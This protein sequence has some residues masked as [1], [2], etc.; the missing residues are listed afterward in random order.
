[1]RRGAGGPLARRPS[2]RSRRGTP[3][4][5]ATFMDRQLQW[6]H[7]TP[8][9]AMAS[10]TQHLTAPGCPRHIDHANTT[11]SLSSRLL[12]RIGSSGF[13]CV[14]S[15]AALARN[16]IRTAQFASL[17]CPGEARAVH[18]AIERFSAFIGSQPDDSTAVHSFAAIFSG[19]RAT[20]EEHYERLLWRFL[21]RLHDVD[22][23][24]GHRWAPDAESDPDHPRF[25]LSVASHPFFVIGLHSGASRVARRFEV[26]VLVF[27]SHRQFER[28]RSDGRYAKMQAATRARDRALQGSINPN[29]ADFG[30][31]AETRQYSGRHVEADWRCPLDIR[32]GARH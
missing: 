28:L 13:P 3:I 14:G 24:R 8:R 10:L 22:R 27:N 21:Q 20:G 16:R 12:R 17:A 11:S 18:A 7:S 5:H 15:K 26:P 6:R 1:M 4:V 19:P 29:L 31:A 23:Q 32:T 30:S 25:S 9:A 2:Q